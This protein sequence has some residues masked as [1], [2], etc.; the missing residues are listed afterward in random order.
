M[1]KNENEVKTAIVQSVNA[2]ERTAT[3]LFP[4]TK[5]TE[6]VSLLELDPHGTSTAATLGPQST[7][8]GLGVQR[9]DFV[10]IHRPG[11]TNGYEIPRVPRIGELESWV[12]E[13][14]FDQG[15][16]TGWRRE[17]AELGTEVTAKLGRGELEELLPRIPTPGDRNFMWIGEVTGVSVLYSVQ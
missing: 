3:V 4:D 2:V 14:P 8:D 12:R 6:L 10:F 11:T 7:A 16:I 13:V 5:T 1:W 17:M 9:G 15:Q